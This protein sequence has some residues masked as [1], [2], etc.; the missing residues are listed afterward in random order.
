MK[1]FIPLVTAASLFL[2]AA[3]AAATDAP[4]NVNEANADQLQSLNGVGPATAEAI[5][6]DRAQNG[7]FASAEEL[8]RVNGIGAATL[9]SIRER[10]AIE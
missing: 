3:G 10:V 1:P 5:V 6:E 7:P 2:S 8:V 9:E 4:I